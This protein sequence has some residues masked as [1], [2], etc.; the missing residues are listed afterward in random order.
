MHLNILLQMLSR[1]PVK[2]KQ[3]EAQMAG[4]LKS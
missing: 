2:L 1:D 4:I 3:M